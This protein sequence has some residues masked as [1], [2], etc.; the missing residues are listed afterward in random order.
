MPLRL[1]AKIG[2]LKSNEPKDP[3]AF[4]GR[5]PA[6][7][8]LAGRFCGTGGTPTGSVGVGFH[9]LAPLARVCLPVSYASHRIGDTDTM[10]QGR[11]RAIVRVAPAHRYEAAN[12]A[13]QVIQI[14]L[15]I[16]ALTM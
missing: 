14:A 6:R 4:H 10:R 8:G 5:F 7:L 1:R 9:I 15:A 12:I 2:T 3:E 13:L 11:R 16:L